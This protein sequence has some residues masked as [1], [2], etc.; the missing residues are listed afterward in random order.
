MFFF[1]FSE[2]NAAAMLAGACG[3]LLVRLRRARAKY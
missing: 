1:E 3:L 2:P